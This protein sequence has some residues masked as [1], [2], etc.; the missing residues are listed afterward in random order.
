MSEGFLGRGL[1]TPRWQRVGLDGYRGVGVRTLQGTA[2][3][4][5]ATSSASKS[6]NQCED[7]RWKVTLLCA[8]MLV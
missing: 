2:A 4:T 1:E 5:T 6:P 7:G 8:P 3:S